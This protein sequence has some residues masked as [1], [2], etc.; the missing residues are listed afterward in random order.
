[1]MKKTIEFLRLHILRLREPIVSRFKFCSNHKSQKQPKR[2]QEEGWGP[3]W[4][5]T[6]RWKETSQ[7]SACC[8]LIKEYM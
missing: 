8:D 4:E 6:R 7:T 5:E 2:L 1:M 3:H